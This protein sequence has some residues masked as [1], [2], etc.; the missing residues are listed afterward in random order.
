[1]KTF[2]GPLKFIGADRVGSSVL[3]Q[4]QG[5][6]GQSKTFLIGFKIPDGHIRD[7]ALF[8]SDS[9]ELDF[10]CKTC[11]RVSWW[12]AQTPIAQRIL[13][14][15]LITIPKSAFYSVIF[16]AIMGILSAMFFLYFNLH[17]RRM[18]SVK[19]SSPKLNNVA[20]VG[21]ILVYLSVILLGFDTSNVNKYVDEL[22][23]VRTED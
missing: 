11:F 12:N 14:V 1:M 16:V 2:Q 19:I 4:I 10:E 17:F 13:K 21:C 23:T 9:G 6:S 5:I 20:V 18:K 15:S 7:I 3:R 22:C 8:D